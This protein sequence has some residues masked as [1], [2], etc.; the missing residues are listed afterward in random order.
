MRCFLPENCEFG[1][2]TAHHKTITARPGRNSGMAMIDKV[3]TDNITT[4][5]PAKD[6]S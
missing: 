6:E 4:Q 2:L 5:L 3:C 1:I